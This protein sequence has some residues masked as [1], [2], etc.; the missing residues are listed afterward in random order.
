MNGLH[1]KHGHL[2][3]WRNNVCKI[4]SKK[5]LRT[6]FTLGNDDHVRIDDR[7][8]SAFSRQ[9]GREYESSHRSADKQ[10]NHNLQ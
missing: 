1:D 8:F 10:I 6:R 5:F 4:C 3:S 2:S 9:K 7:T